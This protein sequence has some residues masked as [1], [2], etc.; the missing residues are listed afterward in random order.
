MN[1]RS[2]FCA[3]RIMAARFAGVSAASRENYRIHIRNL[4]FGCAN[5]GNIFKIP[6]WKVDSNLDD[7]TKAHIRQE[8]KEEF[9]SDGVVVA[10]QADAT[11]FVYWRLNVDDAT[12]HAK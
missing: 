9:E 10:E 5:R 3:S 12:S 1:S 4:V 8:I 11:G 7:P 2:A 6:V